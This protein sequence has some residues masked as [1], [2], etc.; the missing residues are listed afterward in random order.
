[1]LLKDG[2]KLIL[3]IFLSHQLVNI[4]PQAEIFFG[5][6]KGF[7]CKAEYFYICQPI[8]EVPQ[9]TDFTILVNL[10]SPPT[11]SQ[12]SLISKTVITAVA[13]NNVVQHFDVQQCGCVFNFICELF[14]GPAG[15]Q[16]A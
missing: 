3:V 10:L 6:L 13:Y 11:A 4:S 12:Q 14:I 8:F 16:A 9:N 7:L 15:Y 5:Y 2:H 1:M